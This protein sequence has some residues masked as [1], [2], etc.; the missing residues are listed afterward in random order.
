MRPKT[1]VLHLLLSVCFKNLDDK[2]SVWRK[3]FSY[4]I[5][6][7][8][9]SVNWPYFYSGPI[10]RLKAIEEFCSWLIHN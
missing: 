8:C 9:T 7:T 1:V 2:A 6:D 3:S 4:F 5:L 10:W